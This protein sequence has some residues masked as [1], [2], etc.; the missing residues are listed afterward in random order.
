MKPSIFL[1]LC[2]FKISFLFISLSVKP[3][4]SVIDSYSDH[5]LTTVP[6]PV[7]NSEPLDYE[8]GPFGPSQSG[9]YYFGN[10]RVVST[11]ITRY[12]NSFSFYTTEVSQTDK[13][14]V[15]MIEGSF[16]LQNPF[17]LH[18]FL[19]ED[20]PS[21]GSVLTPHTPPVVADF[22]S[23]FILKLHGFW[24]KSS[25]ELCMVGTGSSYFKDGN[26]LTPAAVLKLHNIKNSSNITTLI[27]GTL[28]SLSPINDNNYFEPISLMT[29]PQMNYSFTF[30]SGDSGDEFSSESDLEENLSMYNI[31]RGRSF[32][33]FSN[34]A[35]K[36][37][38]NLE[39]TGCRS[40]KKCLPVG[41]V[42]QN[43]PGSIS[44]GV[45]N[46]TDVGKR[47]RVFLKFDDHTKLSRL[48]QRFNPDTT[49]IGEGMWDDKK[50]QLHVLLCRFLGRANSW[51]NAYVGNCTTRLSLTYPAILSIKETSTIMGKIWSNKTV[52]DS[53]YFE[54]IVFRS[55]EFLI[56]GLYSLKYEYTELD[57]VRNEC[58]E[59][60]LDRNRRQRYPRPYSSEMK[61][62][63]SVRSSEGRTASGSADALTVNNQFC[64]QAGIALTVI[65]NDDFERPTRWEPQGRANISYKID[66]K[67]H[68]SQKLATKN[69]VS[70]VPDE[71]M[72][73]TAEGVY[74]ADTGGLCMVGCRK[75]ALTDRALGNTSNTSID[76]EILLNFQFAPVKGFEN[77]GYI[78]GRIESTR[79]KSDDLYFDP[80]D[81]SS[82][83]YSREQARHTIWAM[84]LEIVMVV[85]SQTLICLFLRSQVYHARRHPKTLP[86]TSLVMSVILTMGQLIPLVLNYEALFYRKRDQ[87]TMLFQT[88]GW[89]EVNEV[90]IRITSMVAFLLQFRILQQ[91]FS[92]RSNDGNGKGLWF[93]EKMTLL[94][95][96]SL[97]VSGA[98]IV[99]LV[100]RGNYK[101]EIVLL[102]TRPV[103]YWQ[104]ST[105]DD[106]KSYAG[107][108]SDGFLLPQILFNTFSNSREYAL[109]PLFYIGTSLVRLLPHA[110]DLYCDHTYVEYKGTFIYVNPAKEF[111]STAWDVIIPIGVS[112]FA[113]T[114]YLQQQFGG[115]CIVP[116]RF[117]WREN[118]EKIPVVGQS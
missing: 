66:I 82:V 91:A 53:G 9:F 72:E 97:Y 113:V 65:R 40:N 23:P 101:R 6:E 112:L 16:E 31:L 14:G 98:L 17:V 5:C 71:K 22:T 55:T 118:Y 76:C 58:P 43:L 64:K 13:D 33:L 25:G 7:P 38:F 60:K 67:W 83:A 35:I 36:Y 117:R 114:I 87:D 89:L 80:L 48:D 30:A 51:S 85:I 56:E 39:Y 103:D 18:S 75:F 12:T 29:V 19:Y 1:W 47:V 61:F 107:L 37:V 94:V 32:W 34:L 96:L 44:F 49:L 99:L 73:I 70:V 4:S 62:D 10:L 50:N 26:L 28:K 41:G 106:L 24:S 74:D 111:F 15:F 59:R 116:K 81:V 79:D 57:R 93:A 95:T 108:I 8:F 27:T 78:R 110:Y 54:K 104:R 100:Y 86:F 90:I 45:I 20:G 69:Y 42:V 46:C 115:C 21:K 109:S 68:T 105:L 102:P 92:S 88:G 77:G 3:V 84:D 2:T 63:M 11:N 52:H